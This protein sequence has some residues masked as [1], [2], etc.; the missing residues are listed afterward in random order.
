[1][2]IELGKPVKCIRTN[3][4]GL[5]VARI[6]RLGGLIQIEIQPPVDNEGKFQD[7]VWIEEQFLASV[8]SMKNPAKTTAKETEAEET[9]TE[10]EETETSFDGA[11]EEAEETEAEETEAEETES[12]SFDAPA[13]EE[14]EAPK[15]SAKATKAP[16]AKKIT[17]DDVNDAAKAAVT[18]IIGKRGVTGKDAR[19]V[20]LACLKKNFKTET[21]SKLDDEQLAKAVT[22]LA[23][24][25]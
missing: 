22:V 10:A 5:A 11:E 21:I 23:A 12:E 17:T 25:K 3:L 15:K 9:E 18:R 14:D 19:G 2:Q 13:E 1:M 16:K 7:S 24:L 20:V 4:R 6:E 8:Q